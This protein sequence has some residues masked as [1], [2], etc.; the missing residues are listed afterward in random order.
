MID[1]SEVFY[2][3]LYQNHSIVIENSSG[4]SLDFI[5]STNARPQEVSFSVSPMSFNE[6][7]TVTLGA[8]ASMQVFLHF[9]PQPKQSLVP[10][11]G[12]GGNAATAS[13][14]SDP[15]VRELEVYVSCRLVKDFRETVILR[16]IC[17]QPQLMVSLANS[18]GDEPLSQ[19]NMYLTGQPTFL[20]L[21]FPMLE[22]TLSMPELS[23]KAAE[24]SE[25]YLVVHNTK[26]DV[27]A[28]L[29]LRNDSMFFSLE[30]DESLMQPGT[31]EVDLLENGVCA[32]R[33]STLLVTIQP[34][35]AA[36]FR[37]KPDVAALWKH[38]QLWD[39][40][41]KEHV[42]LYNIK[43]FAEHYQNYEYTWKWLITYHQESLA[44]Q[45]SVDDSSFQPSGS[46]APK[47]AEILSDLENALDLASPLSP[48][49][50]T[51]AAIQDFNEADD[52]IHETRSRDDLYQLLQSYR[53]L[54]FDFYY[55]TDELVWYGVRGNAVR[56]SL[57]LADLAYGVVFNHEVF[58][59][60]RGDSR[61]GDAALDAVAFPRL[62]LPWV[63][64]L[65]HFLSFFPE[66]QEATQPLRHV[67]EQLRKFEL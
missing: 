31:V 24:E 41:V 3:K 66:N 17:S 14:A 2:H 40:S 67:Y 23:A 65:G 4:L 43:Q 27:N 49:N 34:L 11:A 29:A 28:R 13:Q 20:G 46:S 9:R 30:I 52:G 8:H 59:I 36:I 6:V 44:T 12:A 53:A 5:L 58:Q 64:Q 35:S 18:A 45:F 15:W 54:Y 48:R 62:L 25:K 38:H 37:V 32:G 33:R 56:H 22:S 57:A 16:A 7:S 21:V 42:T 55:I 47:L 1:Y 50:L 61:S 60:F 26:S 39:H 19:R 51:H 10:S 63:R